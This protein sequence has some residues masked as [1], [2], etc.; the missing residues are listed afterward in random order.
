MFGA[1]IGDVIGSKF[2]FN[3][4]KTQNFELFSK[5]STF[6]DDSVLTVA[7]A[8][9]LLNG[10]NYSDVYT[11]Y[12]KAYPN[13]GWGGRFKAIINTYDKLVPYNSFG[14]GSAMRIAPI[15]WYCNTYKEVLEESKKSA[16]VSHNHEEGIK[17]GQAV[18]LAILLARKGGSKNEIRDAVEY[19]LGYKLDKD[20]KSFPKNNFDETCQGTIPMC[21]ALFLD[22]EDFSDALRKTIVLGGDVDT[23]C[24]IVNSIAE[25]HYGR[26]SIN[27]EWE[28][29]V[30]S[31]LPKDFQDIITKFLKKYVYP[32]FVAP[33]VMQKVIQEVPKKEKSKSVLTEDV[34]FEL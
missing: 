26:Q 6:T 11:K 7:T 21:F 28:K 9:V 10:G 16:E 4:T 14:N 2:E 3:N 22:S 33:F 27:P 32:E 5:E 19:T 15:G 12:F 20:L 34:F 29:E 30:W 8:D 13:R 24:C 31:R 18:A 25:A 1:I 17:G 23:N